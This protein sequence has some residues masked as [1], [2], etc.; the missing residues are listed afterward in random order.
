MIAAF[1]VA[2]AILLVIIF[3]L[4]VAVE[5]VWEISFDAKKEIEIKDKLIK[6]LTNRLEDAEIRKVIKSE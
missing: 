6:D 2:I 5:I 3:A 4:I 1:T